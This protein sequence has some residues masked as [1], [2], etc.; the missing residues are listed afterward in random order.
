MSEPSKSRVRRLLAEVPE[1]RKC[2]G[3][4][5]PGIAMQTTAVASGDPDCATVSPGGP[6]QVVPAIKCE[7]CGWSV[8]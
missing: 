6:G 2:G 4:M 1:C 7:G 5:R 8:R 3:R